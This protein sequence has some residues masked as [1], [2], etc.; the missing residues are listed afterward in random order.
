MGLFLYD[1]LGGR[2]ILPGT[3]SLDLRSDPAGAPLQ[4]Q[5]KKAYEYSD[6]WVQDARLVVLNAR[7]AEA[8]GAHIH[9][10][11]K[12][13][14]A[15]RVEDHWQIET[16]CRE[17]GARRMRNARALVNAGGPWVM[18]VIRGV[19]RQETDSWYPPCSRQSYCH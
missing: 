3:R 18:D 4:E 11:T 15:K 17:T 19:T 2:G 10:H 8:R 5:Y 16:E 13:I 1:H 14:S 9:T 12:V 7:D 6:C